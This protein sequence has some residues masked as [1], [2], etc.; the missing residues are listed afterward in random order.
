MKTYT[1]SFTNMPEVM[2]R[3]PE[4][5]EVQKFNHYTEA[6]KW[7]SRNKV[8]LIWAQDGISLNEVSQRDNTWNTQTRTW[9]I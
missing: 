1:M 5:R 6:E 3:N 4:T 7:A 8:T 2:V 9:G